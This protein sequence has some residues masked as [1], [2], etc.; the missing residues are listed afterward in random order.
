MG[1]IWCTK[2]LLYHNLYLISFFTFSDETFCRKSFRL[3]K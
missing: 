3:G 1:S 2:I